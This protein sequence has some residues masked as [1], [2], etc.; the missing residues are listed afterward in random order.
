MIDIL[1]HLIYTYIYIDRL[2]YQ[3]SCWYM[4][5]IMGSC[6]I[7][8][9]NSTPWDPTS[10]EVVECREEMNKP[11]NR[12]RVSGLAWTPK[13]SRMIAFLPFVWMFFGPLFF[14]TCCWGLGIWSLF[15]LIWSFL[16]L[17]FCLLGF[18]GSWLSSGCL[19]GL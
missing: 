18:S 12:Q 8:T 7:S 13:V 11:G 16:G 3:N 5:S 17:I 6:R 2:Y 9:I 10:P 15:G 19:S 4:R 14:F 1:H